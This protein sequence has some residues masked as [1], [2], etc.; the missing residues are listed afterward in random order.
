MLP[1]VKLLS[2]FAARSSFRPPPAPA[3]PTC[4]RAAICAFWPWSMSPRRFSPSPSRG[5]RLRR[6]VAGSCAIWK[7][8]PAA[9][10]SAPRT[11]TAWPPL[12]M[13]WLTPSAVAGTSSTTRSASRLKPSTRFASAS[14]TT[15][16]CWHASAAV[17]SLSMKQTRFMLWPPVAP[18]NASGA[19]INCS[20]RLSPAFSISA[21]TASP[22]ASRSSPRC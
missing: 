16:R 7:P 10:T 5:P 20:T 18:S 1:R 13:P 17:F 21:T 22:A 14:R 15:A 9:A 2:T 8:P 19:R 12:A 6:C 11:S 4:L 3:K